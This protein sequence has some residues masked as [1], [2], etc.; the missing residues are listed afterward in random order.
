MHSSRSKYYHFGRCHLEGLNDTVVSC[1]LEGYN[2][3]TLSCHLQGLQD[4]FPQMTNRNW[5]SCYL[6]VNT[7]SCH[8]YTVQTHTLKHIPELFQFSLL[9]FSDPPAHPSPVHYFCALLCT[10]VCVCMHECVH[11]VHAIQYDHI[12]FSSFYVHVFVDLV[13][14]GV[15]TFTGLIQRCRNDHYYYYYLCSILT[16]DSFSATQILNFLSFALYHSHPTPLNSVCVCVSGHVCV[17]SLLALCAC[18]ILCVCACVCVCVCLC[19]CFCHALYENVY[20][21]IFCML[22]YVPL[23]CRIMRICAWYIFL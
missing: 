19:A 17:Y 11:G 10:S 23:I 18:V 8:T 4:Q 16:S 7:Q 21:H 15:L 2:N 3:E 20:F 5:V 13:K 6:C 14:C 1:Y 12:L 9:P 22:V